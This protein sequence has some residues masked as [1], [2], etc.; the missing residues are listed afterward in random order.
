MLDRKVFIVKIK[1][2]EYKKCIEIEECTEV[3]SSSKETEMKN[4]VLLLIFDK[5]A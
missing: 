5:A 3:S 1:L 4:F 2:G